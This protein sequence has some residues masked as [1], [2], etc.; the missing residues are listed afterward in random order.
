[1]PKV[2]LKEGETVEELLRRFKRE[3]NAAGILPEC[4]KREFF[5]PK[6]LARKLKSQ[7][8]RIKNR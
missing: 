6:G 5:T 4:R 7:A 1:M 3:V 8:A 2:V